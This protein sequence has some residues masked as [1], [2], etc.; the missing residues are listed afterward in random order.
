MSSMFA[1]SQ[2]IRQVCFHLPIWGFDLRSHRIWRCDKTAA[3]PHPAGPPSIQLPQSSTHLVMTFAAGLSGAWS[4]VCVTLWQPVA[5]LSE[6]TASQ[7]SELHKTM[8]HN[9]WMRIRQRH[10][11]CC[12]IIA[13]ACRVLL[14]RQIWC[15]ACLL[16]LAWGKNCIQ[17]AFSSSFFGELDDFPP[18]FEISITLFWRDTK[19]CLVTKLG[20]SNGKKTVLTPFVSCGTD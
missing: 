17:R 9:G 13:Q 18:N 1:T 2:L 14:L 4:S 6:L 16:C 20:V 15:D 19:N 10:H 8:S 5:C 12:T 11:P 7:H 3:F